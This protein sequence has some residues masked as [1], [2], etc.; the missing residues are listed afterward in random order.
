MTNNAR[1]TP[2][3]SEMT[4]PS[5]NLYSIIYDLGLQQSKALLNFGNISKAVS[6]ATEATRLILILTIEA[7]RFVCKNQISTNYYKLE[8]GA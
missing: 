3:P 6:F 1:A 5:F 4:R 7:I 8:V 2:I